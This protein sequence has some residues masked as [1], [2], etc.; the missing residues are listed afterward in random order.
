[1]ADEFDPEGFVQ[2]QLDAYNA[3]NLEGF[4]AEYTDDVIAYRLPAGEAATTGKVAFGEHYRKN[5]FTLP[6]L[7]A[8]L[9]N[10][11]VFGNKV[12]DQERIHGVSEQPM[13]VAAIY[14]VAP[15]GIRRVWFLS[16][17]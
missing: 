6:N 7:H 9:V 11:M 15:S 4:L 10:R 5:R 2:R 16:G 1:M 17:E 14:E 12:I 3:R 8:E 13:E